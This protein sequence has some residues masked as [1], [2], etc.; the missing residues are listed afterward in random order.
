MKNKKILILFIACFIS[1][2]LVATIVLQLNW[3]PDNTVNKGQLVRNETHLQ[4]W[5]NPNGYLWTMVVVSKSDCDDDSCQKRLESVKNIQ[6]ALGKKS[7]HVAVMVLS[8]KANDV[9]T[10]SEQASSQN[11]LS[12][13]E[14]YLVDHMGLVVLSYPYSADENLNK[15]VFKGMLSDI[16]KLLNYARSS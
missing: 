7:E 10:P 14:I 11:R 5:K 3:L 1:P 9:F 13:D 16:K 2:F 6:L 15:P 12:S 8:Q 4:N